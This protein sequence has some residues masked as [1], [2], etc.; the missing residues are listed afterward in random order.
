MKRRDPL[1]DRPARKGRI[2]DRQGIHKK[3]PKRRK[4]KGP[5]QRP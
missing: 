1:G 5:R 2:E 4:I 3:V